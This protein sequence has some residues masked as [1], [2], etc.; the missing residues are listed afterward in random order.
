MCSRFGR[1]A[2]SA[3]RSRYSLFNWPGKATP[4][5]STRMLSAAPS[6]RSSPE[7]LWLAKPQGLYQKQ[8]LHVLDAAVIRHE[9]Q[10]R[11]RDF[12]DGEALVF[13]CLT[14]ARA[15]AIPGAVRGE[16]Q[17]HA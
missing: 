3:A 14:P 11:Q 8:R 16:E 7:Q 5:R 2:R 10:L 9:G 12:L 17:V 6:L 13:R 4:S 15:L 1:R